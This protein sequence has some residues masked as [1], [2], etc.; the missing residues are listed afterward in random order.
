MFGR[1]GRPRGLAPLDH[2]ELGRQA[3]MGS[4]IRC[5]ILCP[6]A[7]GPA[8]PR[9]LVISCLASLH[10]HPPLLFQRAEEVSGG[11]G[12]GAKRR[13]PRGGRGGTKRRRPRAGRRGRGVGG[14]GAEDTRSTAVRC[15]ISTDTGAG[16]PT[17]LHGHEIPAARRLGGGGVSDA[18]MAEW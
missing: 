14:E 4:S 15:E 16:A 1:P 9:R 2:L 10:H 7:R 3:P 6:A 13:G 17:A 8:T 11:A 5:F 12:G 18:D